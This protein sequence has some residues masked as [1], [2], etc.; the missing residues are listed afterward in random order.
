MTEQELVY[1]I[2]EIV[3][4]EKVAEDKIDQRVVRA[5]LR[6][7][8]GSKLS[9]Y[10][11]EGITIT[12]EVF[13]YLGEIEFTTT[14]KTSYQLTTSKIPTVL[15]FKDGYGLYFMKGAINVPLVNSEDFEFSFHSLYNTYLPKVKRQGNVYTLYKGSLTGCAQDESDTYKSILGMH[16]E[17]ISSANSKGGMSRNPYAIKM[18]CWAVLNNPE[19]AP[20]Y[21]WRKSPYPF[22]NEIVDQ[23]I[24]SVL[25][26][27]FNIYLQRKEDSIGN[28]RE[29]N[30][31]FSDEAG[32]EG[33]R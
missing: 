27:E 4:L 14:D 20:D 16:K 31:Q 13:Q 12:D 32:Y 15:D 8:R 30:I 11:K 22:P 6:N 33:Q 5:Y 3:R 10:S 25:A 2:L 19:D 1:R 7:H 28:D 29:D 23:L 26:R 24:N 18:P 21:D 9:T 17:F